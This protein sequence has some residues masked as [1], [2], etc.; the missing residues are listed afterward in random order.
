MKFMRFAAMNFM[1]HTSS[2]RLNEQNVAA[3]ADRSAFSAGFAN[4]GV[5]RPICDGPTVQM[6]FF[7][8]RSDNY[9]NQRISPDS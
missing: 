7:I 3:I 2:L 4:L 1:F 9:R 6:E 8:H 5:G